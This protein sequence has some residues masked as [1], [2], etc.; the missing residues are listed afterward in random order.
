MIL[1]NFKPLPCPATI[2]DSPWSSAHL[3]LGSHVISGEMEQLMSSVEWLEAKLFL[4]GG[5]ELI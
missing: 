3:R 2:R 1:F 5:L 4:D